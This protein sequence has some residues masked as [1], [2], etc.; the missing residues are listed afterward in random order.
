MIL[1]AEKR[2]TMGRK[3]KSL[4]DKG[5]LPAVLYG[6]GIDTISLSVNSKSFEEFLKKFGESSIFTIKIANETE[7]RNV[8]IHD[9][10]SDPV[11]STIDHVDFYQVRMDQKTRTKVPFEFFGISLSEKAGDIIIKNM[12][13]LEVEALPQDL[14]KSIRIDI[15][16][17]EKQGDK[18]LVS[19]IGLSDK[20][21]IIAEQNAVIALSEAARTEEEINALKETP[22]TA[23]ISDIKTEQEEKK[24]EKE[25][26]ATAEAEVTTPPPGTKK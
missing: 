14:P 24:K 10:A 23:D 12:H 8:L 26:K 16:K 21:K 1:Q 17:I 19:D 5:S 2:E 15:S 25:A 22:V 7:P 3:V 20:I 6:Q 18:I 4:R 11:T 9:I 13:E